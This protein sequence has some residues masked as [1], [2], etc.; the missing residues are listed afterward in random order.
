MALIVALALIPVL[1]FAPLPNQ[2]DY[3]R[4][5]DDET[6][7]LG[8]GVASPDQLNL[9]RVVEDGGSLGSC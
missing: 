8:V 3:Y 2:I 5:V 7:A 4:L 6:I 9:S 1:W